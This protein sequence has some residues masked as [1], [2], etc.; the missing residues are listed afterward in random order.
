MVASL[1][2]VRFTVRLGHHVLMVGL[3]YLILWRVPLIVSV[4]PHPATT[5]SSAKAASIFSC[6]QSLHTTQSRVIPAAAT[7]TAKKPA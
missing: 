3:T 7:A 2:L 1:D 4:G 5:G 6:G